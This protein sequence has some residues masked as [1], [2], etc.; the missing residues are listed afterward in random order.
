MTCLLSVLSRQ[1]PLLRPYLGQ[2]P[3]ML[4][5]AAGSWVDH[6]SDPP[7]PLPVTLSN[8]SLCCGSLH[9]LPVNG[10]MVLSYTESL[11]SFSTTSLFLL[12]NPNRVLPGPASQPSQHSSLRVSS[13]PTLALVYETAEL[14]EAGT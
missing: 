5:T 7:P 11:I 2:S 13:L 4:R 14:S 3:I 9:W 8:E 1:S 12:S 10:S 6:F